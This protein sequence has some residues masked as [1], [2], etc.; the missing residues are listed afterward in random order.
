MTEHDD[1]DDNRAPD[2]NDYIYRGED[3]PTDWAGAAPPP[4]PPTTPPAMPPPMPPGAAP[5]PPPNVPGAPPPPPATSGPATE[6]PKRKKWPWIVGAL[7]VFCALPLGGCV[8]LIAFGFSEIGER[9]DAIEM[10]ADEFMDQVVAGRA[11]DTIGL[12]DGGAECLETTRFVQLLESDLPTSDTWESGDIGFVDRND[13]SYLANVS[14]AE[15][16]VFPGR[17]QDGFAIVSG[18]LLSS[19][20]TAANLEIVLL[21]PDDVWRVCS[22]GVL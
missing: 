6:G 13:N 20:S 10:V 12:M 11:A 2:G 18:R 3:E 17:E 22:V 7:V 5:G 1:P 15:E 9:E 14:E 16:F 8:A 21:K 4:M 19:G